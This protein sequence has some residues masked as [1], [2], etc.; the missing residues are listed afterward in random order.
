MNT[1][2]LHPNQIGPRPDKYAHI[3]LEIL[4][5][6][7]ERQCP[8]ISPDGKK[9]AFLA[10]YKH[11]MNIHINNID[12]ET[13]RT[14]THYKERG[15][16]TFLWQWDS[17][18]I[19]YLRD[20]NGD[21]NWHLYRA[22]IET[23]EI[24]DLTPFEEVKAQI[25]AMSPDVPNKILIALNLRKNV[26]DVYSIDLNS[27]KLE[28][29]TEN[30]GDV[31][32][33]NADN[34]L[35]V[36]IAQ[37]IHHTGRNEIRIRKDRNSPWRRFRMW[38][39]DED[40]GSDGNF[41]DV[42]G[43]SSDNNK[44]WLISS[45][46]YNT[47]RLLQVDLKTGKA[48]VSGSDA[49]Y[50]ACDVLINPFTHKLSACC[51]IRE[52][53]EW[54]LIDKSLETDFVR[55]REFREGIFNI[56]SGDMKDRI[57]VIA[58]ESDISPVSYYIY[59]RDSK[60]FKFLFSEKPGLEKYELAGM[61]TIS[62]KSRDGLKINGYI[63][64]PV[65]LKPA[66]LPTVL[67]VH[68]GPWMRDRWGL[69]LTTQWLANRGYIVL[70]VNYRG[71]MGYGKDFLDAG[72]R[73]W[74]GKML[75]DLIDAKRWAVSMGYSDPGRFAIMG[76]S[77]G[78]YAVLA[79]LA[80]APGEF[81]CGVDM[82]GPSNLV[83]F[84][85]SI[86]SHWK[87]MKAFLDRRIGHLQTE[88]EFLKSRSPLFHSGNITSPLIIAQGSNDPR[89]KKRE[90]DQM[91]SALQNNNTPVEYILYPDEGHGFSLEKNRLDFY[92]KVESFLAIYPGGNY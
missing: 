84:L 24:T 64:F 30:P 4:F 72:N 35:Q 46:G 36:R 41:G 23:G 78:G 83:S 13:A 90:S 80:F 27:G 9:I 3:P 89:V 88:K 65:G 92:R 59:M 8:L 25:V 69:N 49:D 66:N 62:F 82:F 20:K 14:L 61:D 32:R 21:E 18:H 54:D 68:S 63:T 11:I 16:Q 77:Y 76:A 56:A 31:A 79:A 17:L 37:A 58:Y 19:L 47:A 45:A 6:N 91:L 50:D 75:N 51:F 29:D 26:H 43:F 85:E 22:D 52:K 71:S 10:P 87:P 1:N 55:I 86:P 57:W 12:G 74:G 67:L 15:I 28:L 5:G 33:W 73:E 2:Y 81:S 60:E 70:Q 44:M 39:P 53:Q 40:R 42:A 34:D 7:P 48:V 38:I